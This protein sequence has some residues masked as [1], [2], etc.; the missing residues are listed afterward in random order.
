MSDKPAEPHNWWDEAW[1]FTDGNIDRVCENLHYVAD[2]M[3]QIRLIDSSFHRGIEEAATLLRLLQQA[4][5]S[6]EREQR[7]S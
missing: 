6:K 7:A 4:L 3:S 5:R 2:G 1:Q